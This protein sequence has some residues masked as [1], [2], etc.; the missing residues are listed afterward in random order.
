MIFDVSCDTKLPNW[1]ASECVSELQEC[2]DVADERT[3]DDER[4]EGESGAE[5]RRKATQ[6]REEVVVGSS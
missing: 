2:N 3:I 4:K 1:R 5:I 6:E